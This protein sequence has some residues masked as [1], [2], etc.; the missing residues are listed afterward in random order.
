VQFGQEQVDV[1]P[2]DFYRPLFE[3]ATGPALALQFASQRLQVSLAQADAGYNRHRLAAPPLRFPTHPHNAVTSRLFPL[4]A[5]ATRYGL[6]ALGAETPFVGRIDR[7]C[8]DVLHLGVLQLFTWTCCQFH[9][10]QEAHGF[11]PVAAA[12]FPTRPETAAD[13]WALGPAEEKAAK[14]L[15]QLHAWYPRSLARGHSG[16]GA[17]N[18]WGDAA[19]AASAAAFNYFIH[20]G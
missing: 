9:G 12:H 10:G 20:V 18:G 1:V 16:Y 6:A 17:G 14:V 3:S 15:G 4:R 5:Y 13:Q 2:L 8:I 19:G 11:L 7:A